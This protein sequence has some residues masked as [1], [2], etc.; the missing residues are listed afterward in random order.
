MSSLVSAFADHFTDKILLLKLDL[1]SKKSE[2]GIESTFSNSLI[3]HAALTQPEQRILVRWM[4][5]ETQ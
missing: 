2:L 3:I 4:G 5:L 1:C